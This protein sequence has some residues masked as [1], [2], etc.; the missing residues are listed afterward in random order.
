MVY[1]DSISPSSRGRVYSGVL[2][3]SA[4]SGAFAVD[5]RLQLAESTEA[6]RRVPGGE[7]REKRAKT[8]EFSGKMMDL[9]RFSGIEWWFHG[10]L[11]GFLMGVNGD[12][13]DFHGDLLVICRDFNCDWMDLIGD[14][15]VIFQG[16]FYLMGKN[17]GFFDGNMNIMGVGFYGKFMVDSTSRNGDLNG[18]Y[19]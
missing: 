19:I 1:E 8:G 4:K 10:D 15:L 14:S 9:V 5:L 16:F 6:R 12:L 17:D 7:H 11:K 18:R 2:R 3:G 13:R